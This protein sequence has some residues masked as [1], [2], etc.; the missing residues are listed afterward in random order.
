[1]SNFWTLIGMRSENKKNAHLKRHLGAFFKDSMTLGGCQINLID[2]NYYLQ[3]SLEIFDKNSA[4]KIWSK[5][6]KGAESAL[7]HAN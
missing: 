5:K 7:P 3:K 6:D 2:V 1:M 4:N